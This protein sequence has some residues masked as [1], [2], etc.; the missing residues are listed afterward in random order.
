MATIT[1]NEQND[2][3]VDDDAQDNAA[4]SNRPI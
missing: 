4:E 3:D 2:H 1:T